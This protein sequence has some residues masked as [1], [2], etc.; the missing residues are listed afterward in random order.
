LQ[1]EEVAMFL[2]PWDDIE[3]SKE[4]VDRINSGEPASFA[5]DGRRVYVTHFQ[6]VVLGRI[7]QDVDAII[8]CYPQTAKRAQPDLPILC[9]WDRVTRA[10]FTKDGFVVR[11][12]RE[13]PR[14]TLWQ[15]V[16]AAAC[17][18]PSRN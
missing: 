1:G 10:G 6:D 18:S 4:A 7:P 12:G 17:S 11:A 14:R 9:P 13:V 16:E 8:C 15:L 3:A 2:V 5:V